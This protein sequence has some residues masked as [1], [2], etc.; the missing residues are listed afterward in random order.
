MYPHKLPYPPWASPVTYDDS[1]PAPSAQSL[2]LPGDYYI[3][4]A[5][6]PQFL[7]TNLDVSRLSNY[8]FFLLVR[9]PALQRPPLA[10]PVPLL[11]LHHHH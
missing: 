6:L 7:K 11:A 8:F 10:P 4:P 5:H 3:P 9:W 1:Q 2:K